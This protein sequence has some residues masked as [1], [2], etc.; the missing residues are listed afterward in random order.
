MTLCQL[1][2]S[3]EPNISICFEVSK[4]QRRR[5]DGRVVKGEARPHYEPLRRVGEG[6]QEDD[7]GN[8]GEDYFTPCRGNWCANHFRSPSYA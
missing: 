6:G 7:E 4:R 5:A 2:H 8:T 3:A 1:L